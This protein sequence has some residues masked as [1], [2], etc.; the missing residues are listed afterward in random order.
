MNVPVVHAAAASMDARA[1]D[2]TPDYTIKPGDF[3]IV[4]L[5][6]TQYYVD[7]ALPS[8]SGKLGI[9]GKQT[10]W[11]AKDKAKP[12]Y[13][14]TKLNI[15]YVAHLGDIV[16][17]TGGTANNLAAQWDIAAAAMKNLETAGIPYGVT[18]G[19]H[20]YHFENNVQD[21]GTGD[22]NA[23]FGVDHLKTTYPD[24][25]GNYYPYYP[26]NPAPTP[27]PSTADNANNYM[28]FSANGMNFIVVNLAYDAG[29]QKSEND[30]FYTRYG[31]APTPASPN[32]VLT[33]ANTVLKAYPARRAIVVSHYILRPPST[34][35]SPTATPTV[36]GTNTNMGNQ[37]NAIY[38][39]L[40]DCPN[41]SMML[42]GHVGAYGGEN[43]TVLGGNVNV[44]L[45]DYQNMTNG[46]DGY[47]RIMTFSPSRNKIYVRTFSPYNTTPVLTTPTSKFELNGFLNCQIS[48]TANT[49]TCGGLPVVS[50]VQTPSGGQ[51]VAKITTKI[52][53]VI[54]GQSWSLPNVSFRV[55]Y[56]ST[57]TGW[58]VNIGDSSTNDGYGG[59][60]GTQSN[61][62]EMQI[63]NSSMMVYGN[64][65]NTPPGGGLFPSGKSLALNAQ[66]NVTLTVRNNYLGWENY[67]CSNCSITSPFLY[68]LDGRPDI[69]GPINYDIYAAF[70]R[71]IYDSTR[72]GTGVSTVQITF[73]VSN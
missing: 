19:N 54:A 14:T 2:F 24:N 16:N 17:N 60:S 11:I 48:L 12:A 57:P 44:L 40:K 32:P 71:T 10:D 1:L 63:V 43:K 67:A 30:P 50:M 58:T 37:G 47:L 65:Y 52:T 29:Y 8:G 25:Y 56:G 34:A 23:H 21:Y 7:D 41:L 70:N 31:S 18:L 35:T 27:T 9:F 46:G 5:P 51:A 42:S 64:D 61:D 49:H 38:A 22:F 68:A 33:W 69:E 6:D 36:P 55:T 28:L 15:V 26:G 66:Y 3:T 45:S 13:D 62:A 59:D 53:P 72:S 20:D 73:P 4:A 39:A